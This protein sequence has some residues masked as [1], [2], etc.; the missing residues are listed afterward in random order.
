MKDTLD[1]NNPRK[2]WMGVLA[3]APEGRVVALLDEAIAR[4]AFTCYAPLKSEAP[5]CAAVREPRV[6]PLIL[7]R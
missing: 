5:W 2:A 7:A 6:H 1:E 4:P 3:K